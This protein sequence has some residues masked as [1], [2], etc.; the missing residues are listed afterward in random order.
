MPPEY[1]ALLFA[2]TCAGTVVFLTTHLLFDVIYHVMDW[3]K[4]S[5][6]NDENH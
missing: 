1:A 4:G 3:M 2:G 5:S 6:Q